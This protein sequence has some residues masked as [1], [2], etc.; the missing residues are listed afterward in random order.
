MKLFPACFALLFVAPIVAQSGAIS[1]NVNGITCTTISGETGFNGL[2]YQIGGTV[3]TDPSEPPKP[4]K[5][6]ALS[7]LVVTKAFDGCS[8]P[9]IRL[10][11]SEKPAPTLTLIQYANAGSESMVPVLT[12][13]LS[14]AVMNTYELGGATDTH[15]TEAL[16]FTYSK[17][18][19][20]SVQQ[21]ADGSFQPPISACYNLETN[22]LM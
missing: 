1:V 12:L 3:K 8:E 14:N 9:L 2:T 5:V 7:D 10:F 18:C 6:A 22:Q 19:V 4:A 11:L 21:N 17:F 15:P 20:T 16:S 13:T